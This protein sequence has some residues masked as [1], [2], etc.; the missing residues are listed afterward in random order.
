[1]L[2]H[3]ININVST[4]LDLAERFFILGLPFIELPYL[5]TDE[6][7]VLDRLAG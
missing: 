1:M 5:V 7:E 3:E 4:K 2:W 6:M